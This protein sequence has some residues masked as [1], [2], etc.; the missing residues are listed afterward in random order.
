MSTHFD[1]FLIMIIRKEKT[2]VLQDVLR[3]GIYIRF[4][5]FFNIILPH[6]DADGKENADQQKSRD[7]PLAIIFIVGED[8]G[9]QLIHQS[10]GF[11]R[12][13]R[14]KP[15]CWSALPEQDRRFHFAASAH[16]TNHKQP[17]SVW[18]SRYR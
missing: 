7:G 3:T 6:I 8:F 13:K 1:D 10:A 18:N 14:Q 9:P 5:F 12:A 2:P 15:R 4:S 16:P 17:D 11:G